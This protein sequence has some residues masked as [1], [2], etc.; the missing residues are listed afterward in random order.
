EFPQGVS[1][2]AVKLL[3]PFH[4][5]LFILAAQ[6]QL[7]PEECYGFLK[8]EVVPSLQKTN[9]VSKVEIVGQ[10]QKQATI[11]LDLK[12]MKA[13]E[14]SASEVVVRLEEMGKNIYI[15]NNTPALVKGEFS[16]LEDLRSFPIRF[17][18]NDR[19]VALQEIAEIK[20]ELSDPNA[21]TYLNG[22]PCLM[23]EI[24]GEKDAN[25]LALQREIP[26][27]LQNLESQYSDAN[28]LSLNVLYNRDQNRIIDLIDDFKRNALIAILASFFVVF[29]VFKDFG[30]V[31]VS[32]SSIPLSLCGGFLV[33]NAFGISLNI[34]SIIGFIFSIGLI[35]DDIIIM[36]E[37]IFR[38]METGI[39]PF[40]AT[41]QGVKEMMRPII[42]TTCMI[43]CVGLAMIIVKKTY[44]TQYLTS[45]GVTLFACMVFSLLEALTLGPL[46]CAYCLKKRKEIKQE[47]ERRR[48]LKRGVFFLVKERPKTILIICSVIFVV[49][50]VASRLVQ[51]SGDPFVPTPQ[52]VA[53]IDTPSQISLERQNQKAVV[54]AD[55][56]RKQHPE[57]ENMGLRVERGL[58]TIYFQLYKN[59]VSFS[60]H[61]QDDVEEKLEIL[62][63]LNE[64]NGF[65]VLN[66]VLAPSFFVP[67]FGVELSSY[68]YKCLQKYSS[69]LF[70]RIKKSNSLINLTDSSQTKNNEQIVFLNQPVMNFFGVE[71]VSLANEL[72]VLLDGAEINTV[73]SPPNV[74]QDSI[75][76]EIKIKNSICVSGIPKVTAANMNGKL[77]PLSPFV[78]MSPTN[79]VE[80]SEIRKKNGQ[81]L[82]AI[83]G[84]HSPKKAQENPLKLTQEMLQKGIPSK[85]TVAWS[86]LSQL[87]DEIS[88][89]QPHLIGLALLFIYIITLLLYRSL[90]LPLIVFSPLPFAFIGS[91][92]ALL[93]TGSQ[94]NVFAII[95]TVVPIGIAAKN[96]VILLQYAN[97]LI[98]KNMD[99]KEA[100]CS[101]LNVR[102]RPILM[103]AFG[104]L[105]AK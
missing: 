82:V 19:A 31:F 30:S 57:I 5:P 64:I 47:E 51:A 93:V 54:W 44:Y 28:G 102:M 4:T 26:S 53:H 95:G 42:G 60:H 33:L 52:M 73:Y 79:S 77:V 35:I 90:I 8:D 98:E 78:S 72:H 71:T 99:S 14:I 68:D 7:L 10:R 15:Q 48:S 58:Q 6:A 25:L 9:G 89:I 103:T 24:Y 76:P 39:S 61:I 29:W 66:G 63:S 3:G 46:L 16:S 50:I 74:I 67:D 92:I 38:Y 97:R 32:I 96:G 34:Y 101:A 81:Y 49:G 21:Y 91:S 83:N 59:K 70:D 88:K 1:T 65:Y 11:D 100:I 27:K 55:Q 87:I 23:L 85:I 94:M 13:R 36:R 104:V 75:K 40:E 2:P 56:L 105:L 20:E 41:R 12:K 62:R 45:P 37:N 80:Q 17:L 18:S 43:L 69:L 86:G 22:K 84:I